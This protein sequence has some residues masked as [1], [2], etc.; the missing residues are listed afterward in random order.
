MIR[1]LPPLELPGHTSSV[2]A[3]ERHPMRIMTRR[4]AGLA[5][6]G[7]DDEARVAVEANFDD[8][9]AAWH[10]RVT[11]ERNAVVADALQRGVAGSPGGVVA[12]VGSGIGTY[13]PLLAA[14]WDC[15]VAFDLSLEMLRHSPPAPGHRV[16]A[17]ASRLPLADGAA[18]AVVLI[19]MLLFPDEVD[20]VL[21][22]EGLVVWVNSSGEQTPIHLPPDEVAEV[23]PGEWEGVRSRAGIGLWCVLRRTQA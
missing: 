17:D 11:P 4:A 22:P 1:D 14:R 23:L 21:A 7:W 18:A 12:E 5:G 2:A 13:S 16:Q 3:D 8:L 6:A 20:R 19:N 15:V 10:S 9:A